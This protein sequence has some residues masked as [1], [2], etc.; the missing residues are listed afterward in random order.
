MAATNGNQFWKLRSKHGRDKIFKTPDILLEAAYEYFAWCESN[1]L[2]EMQ[3]MKIKVSR[4]EEEIQ[5]VSVD[6][7]RAMTISGLTIYLDVN[8]KYFDDFEKGLSGKT[9]KVSK[10]F[11]RIIAHIRSVI[12]NQ[13]FTG[14][15]A[16]FL[17]A[18]IIARDLGLTDKT[19]LTTG[20]QPI[21]MP[22]VTI[23]YE[24]EK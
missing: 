20:G 10:D 12:R 16:G 8:E 11:S 23:K 18:N 2:K 4:D 24:A 7:M 14:A 1:P 3:L 19:D 9:D 6:K 17:N 21:Q 5:K 13:K 22:S 15:A